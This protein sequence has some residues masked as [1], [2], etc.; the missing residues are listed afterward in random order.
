MKNGNSIFNVVKNNKS[1]FHV[2]EKTKRACFF[3]L[4]IMKKCIY[5]D[6]A[7]K[8]TMNDLM[9]NSMLAASYIQ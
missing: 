8:F 6:S 7:L 2:P 9:M 5:S 4:E 3:A 1:L